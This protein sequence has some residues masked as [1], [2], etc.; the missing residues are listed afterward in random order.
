V[1]GGLG[2]WGLGLHLPNH[3]AALAVP[4]RPSFFCSLL[5]PTLPQLFHVF[6]C[7]ALK[8]GFIP[9]L[10]SS[11]SPQQRCLLVAHNELTLE[12]LGGPS[13]CEPSCLLVH[14]RTR[15]HGSISRME[16]RGQIF[17][18]DPLYSA[19][20]QLSSVQFH[21]SATGPQDLRGFSRL[22]SR[23]QL[24]QQKSHKSQVSAHCLPPTSTFVVVTTMTADVE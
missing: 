7:L 13:S 14:L 1:G 11:S 21:P 4:R 20:W 19:I 10:P 22:S 2:A 9:C 12:T 23:P 8:H 15:H 24:Q 18:L 3:L 17:P 6:A 16:T 5:E